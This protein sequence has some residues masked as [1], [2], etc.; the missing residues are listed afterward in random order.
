MQEHSRQSQH[1]LTQNYYYSVIII[2]HSTAQT[3]Q[4]QLIRS[5]FHWIQFLLHPITYTDGS[6]NE[7]PDLTCASRLP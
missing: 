1:Q 7:N 3:W 5:N 6:S 4:A 2:T